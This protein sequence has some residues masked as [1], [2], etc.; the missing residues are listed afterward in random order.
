M[1]DTK[2]KKKGL[3]VRWPLY[4]VAASAVG[5]VGA[6]MAWPWLPFDNSSL[7]LLGVAALA[8]L[9]AYLPLKSIKWGE[10]EAEFDREVDALEQKVVASER[11]P[12]PKQQG[13]TERIRG[14]A[15]AAYGKYTELLSS[16]AS[17]VEKVLAAGVMLEQ[18][19]ESAARDF[20]FDDLPPRANTKL[21]LDRFARDGL[22][23]RDEVEAFR[24]FWMIR[25]KVVHQGYVPTDEQTARLLDLAWRIIRTFGI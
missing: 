9:V 2:K 13:G 7:I 11:A 3:P 1:P 14:A 10:F 17:G 6:R 18:V 15:Q 5:L 25:N 20:K 16:R 23:A 22:I 8:L 12:A 24:D 4:L 21:V 19:I